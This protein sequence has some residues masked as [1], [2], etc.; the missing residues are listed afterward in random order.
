MT[1]HVSVQLGSGESRTADLALKMP[2]SGEA[3]THSRRRRAGR[4]RESRGEHRLLQYA[5]RTWPAG[6]AKVSEGEL[7]WVSS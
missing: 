7:H 6:S 5:R 4:P 1:P 2:V 3:A